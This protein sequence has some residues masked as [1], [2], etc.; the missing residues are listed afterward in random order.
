MGGTVLGIRGWEPSE[1]ALGHRALCERPSQQ[2]WS[3]WASEAPH[4]SG[5]R[6]ALVTAKEGNRFY[7][8]Y[9][10]GSGWLL[11][12]LDVMGLEFEN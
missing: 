8:S 5:C 1:G 11:C 3:W 12:F 4:T 9:S 10:S 6:S 2:W 7:I